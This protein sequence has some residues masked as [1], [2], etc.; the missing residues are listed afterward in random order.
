MTKEL[1]HCGNPLH[2]TCRETERIMAD[3]V[4][5]MGRYVYIT[6]ED[7]TYKVDRHF[8]A[9]HGISGHRLHTYGF[10]EVERKITNE[11]DLVTFEENPQ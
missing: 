3:Q 4:N 2:Y 7:K 11:I 6:C 9:L 5:R 10:E 1:C 8:I